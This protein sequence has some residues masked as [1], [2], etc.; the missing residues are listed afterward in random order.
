M[1]IWLPYYDNSF[2]VLTTCNCQRRANRVGEVRHQPFS[3][4]LLMLMLTLTRG[5]GVLWLDRCCR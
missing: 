4:A 3:S 1:K 2:N 5:D